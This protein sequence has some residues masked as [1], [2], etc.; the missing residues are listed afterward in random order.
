MQCQRRYLRLHG[1]CDGEYFGIG[2]VGLLRNDVARRGIARPSGLDQ[3]HGTSNRS[4]CRATTGERFSSL[5]SGMFK[6][7]GQRRVGY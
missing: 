1:G 4:S 2:T 3:I 6:Y 7:D 5:R